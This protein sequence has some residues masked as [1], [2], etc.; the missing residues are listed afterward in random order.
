M[1]NK[2][3]TFLNNDVLTLSLTF[4][5]NVNA[6]LTLHPIITYFVSNLLKQMQDFFI[7]LF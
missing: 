4:H 1:A 7:V 5:V 2:Q 3:T 6:F